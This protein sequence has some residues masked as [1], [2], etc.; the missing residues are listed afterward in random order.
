MSCGVPEAGV[1]HAGI[2]GCDEMELPA[3]RELVVQLY[4]V[5]ALVAMLWV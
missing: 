2:L 1:Y 4:E 3:M 5:A